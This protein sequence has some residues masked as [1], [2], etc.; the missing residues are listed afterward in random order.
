MGRGNRR[1]QRGNRPICPEPLGQTD[2]QKEGPKS[3]GTPTW[4]G[5]GGPER[6]RNPGNVLKSFIYNGI[7]A[8][9]LG[10]CL[11]PQP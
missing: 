4:E 3:E 1:L 9:A 7:I 6:R 11:S 10:V 2:V 5:G 8:S